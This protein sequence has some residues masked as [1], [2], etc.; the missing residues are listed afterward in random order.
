MRHLGPV[1]V[2]GACFLEAVFQEASNLTHLAVLTMYFSTCIERGMRPGIG[3][4]PSTQ[5]RRRRPLNR[6]NEEP[7]VS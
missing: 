7:T 2:K 4:A 6:Q 3:S 1:L 5:D